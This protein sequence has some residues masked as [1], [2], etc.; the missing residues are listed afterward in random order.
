MKTTRNFASIP[1]IKERLRTL[2]F[3][4]F[5]DEEILGYE[6]FRS[7][8]FS[9]ICVSEAEYEAIEEDKGLLRRLIDELKEIL[10]SLALGGEEVRGVPFH[11]LLD[12]NSV[13]AKIAYKRALYM[14]RDEKFCEAAMSTAFA[15]DYI[16]DA[17]PS[18]KDDPSG[19][20]EPLRTMTMGLLEE[21]L[22]AYMDPNRYVASDCASSCGFCQDPLSTVAKYCTQALESIGAPDTVV[23]E[24]WETAA[25][26][27]GAFLQSR[28]AD[29]KNMRFPSHIPRQAS[30]S[31]KLMVYHQKADRQMIMRRIDHYLEELKLCRVNLFVSQYEEEQPIIPPDY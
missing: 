17:D 15:V 10:D 28:G 6:G 24:A 3:D 23:N 12:R 11:E 14:V 30:A 21:T 7:K 22:T 2:S 9:E 18:L 26:M 27:L 5:G 31:F 13:A 20:A 19:L 29:L 4:S 1:E 25:A 8:A 16:A